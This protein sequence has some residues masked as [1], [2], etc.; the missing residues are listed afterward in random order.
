M[1]DYDR[2]V[3]SN[4]RQFVEQLKLN[5]GTCESL[6]TVQS[7]RMQ[8]QTMRRFRSEPRDVDTEFF[9]SRAFRC[10]RQ[11][12]K[13]SACLRGG[14]AEAIPGGEVIRREITSRPIHRVRMVPYS[15]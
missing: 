8:K 2:S 4:S 1:D 6:D 15:P 11:E 5:R 12:F 13:P 10:E 14:A 3:R 9:A 7:G